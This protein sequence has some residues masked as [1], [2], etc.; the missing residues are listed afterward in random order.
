MWYENSNNHEMQTRYKQFIVE[1]ELLIVNQ[2]ES[3][4]DFL[5]D[6]YDDYSSNWGSYGTYSRYNDFIDVG[7]MFGSDDY[8]WSQDWADAKSWW[9]M[10]AD[11]MYND[12]SYVPYFRNGSS[13]SDF[14]SPGLYY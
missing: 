8:N 12:P 1:Y 13:I 6:L 7:S 10:Q 9:G 3:I 2:E 5:E 11:A 14:Y 4:N